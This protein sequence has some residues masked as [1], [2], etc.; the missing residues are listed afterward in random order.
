MRHGLDDSFETNQ[1][2]DVNIR[3]PHSL[4]GYTNALD[5]MLGTDFITEDEAAAAQEKSTTI[6]RQLYERYLE[7]DTYRLISLHPSQ[8]NHPIRTAAAIGYVALAFPE[9][10]DAEKWANWAFS[11]LDYLWGSRWSVRSGRRR[12]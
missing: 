8:N 2:W 6:N 11:E 10:P 3:M 9:D 7:T 12:L 4:M 1:T 5:L